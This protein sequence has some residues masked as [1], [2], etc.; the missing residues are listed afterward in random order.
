MT[1]QRHLLGVNQPSR[2]TPLR[3]IFFIKRL[4]AKFSCPFMGFE[5]EPSIVVFMKL[6][7][8]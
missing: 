7:P 3:R 1:L 8:E 4:L 2:T 5:G 6:R